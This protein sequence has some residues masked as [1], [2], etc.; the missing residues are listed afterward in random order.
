MAMVA[1]SGSASGDPRIQARR[2]NSF[3]FSFQPLFHGIAEGEG[4]EDGEVDLTPD[5]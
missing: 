1:E 3:S 4:E 5:S 2:V